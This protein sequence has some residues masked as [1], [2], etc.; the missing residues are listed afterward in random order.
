MEGISEYISSLDYVVVIAYL[1]ILIGIGYW[2]SFIKK[3]KSEDNNLFLAGNS[4]SA[5]SI[6]LTMWGTNIGPSSLVASCSIGYTTGIVAGNF[7]WLAFP[8][9]ILLAFVF[10]PKY[11]DAKTTTLPE[12]MG[13]RFGD[14]TRNILAWYA[15]ITILISWL[16]LTLFAGGIIVQ[17]VLGIPFWAS[18][19][20]LV[21]IAVFFTVAGGLEAIAYTNL[22]QMTLMILVS[23]GLTITG[24]YKA[25]GVMAIYESTPKEY[26]NL[27]LPADDP[28]YPWIALILGYPVMGVWFWCTDQS[29]V[30][31]VLGAKNLE[32][33][34]YGANLTGWLKILEVG[35]FIIPGIICFVLFPNLQD[36]DAA[37]MTMVTRLLP[38]GIIGLIIAVIIASLVSTI[39]SALNSLSTV[40]TMDIYVKRFKP[41]ADNKEIIKIGRIVVFVGAVVAIFIA[42][43]VNSVKGLNL[44]DIF[45]AILGFV[46][47]PLTVVFLFGVLWKKTTSR[48]ANF[49]LSVGTAISIGVGAMYLWVFPKD[50]YDFWPHFLLLSFFIFC[51][52]ALM[53][54]L[55]STFDTKSENVNELSFKPLVAPSTKMKL[56]WGSLVVAML[57]LYVLFNGHEAEAKP[58]TTTDGITEIANQEKEELLVEIV[59]PTDNAEAEVS[60][61]LFQDFGIAPE[62]IL[63]WN[64]RILLTHIPKQEIEGI[65]R[66]AKDLALGEVLIFKDLFY[67]YDRS[68][69]EKDTTQASNIKAYCITTNMV[70][71]TAMQN[72]Y[73]KLHVE[74][75]TLWPGVG[76]GFCNEG[77]QYIKMWKSDRRLV[78]IVGIPADMDLDEMSRM[79]AENHPKVQEWNEYMGQF[80][81][82][83]PGAAPGQKWVFMNQIER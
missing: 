73:I 74:Q 40:F 25:G 11:L 80:Q 70:A 3:R 65:A 18:A 44:F 69:C 43:A 60:V 34:Q 45:Q 68:W 77:F 27:L 54:W 29:M 28:N 1:I 81:E 71:D 12:F 58:L 36:P 39:D 14:S 9:L 56:A 51:F 79:N 62:H 31:S 37:Y 2:V 38:N 48:A 24:I 64:N 21:L 20:L 8:F 46:A 66:K 82:A 19:L 30:Q 7:S 57:A 32:Q 4:L 78:L 17:Q 6:G 16:G 10:G 49:T 75:Q 83:L 33:G 76:E 59:L 53:A 22:F 42:M 55:I 50:Q 72:E 47:P 41:K 5:S 52:L 23:L 15:S 35:L 61:G 67:D 13:K 26:W 63:R